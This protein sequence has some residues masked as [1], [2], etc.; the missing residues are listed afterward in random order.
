MP[1]EQMNISLS[2]QMARF[3]RGKVK[4]GEYTNASEVVRDAVRRLQASE[5]ERKSETRD[6]EASLS[7]AERA[8]IRKRVQQGIHDIG[9]G[10][11]EE[12]DE[13]GLRDYFAGVIE[14]GKKRLAAP[15]RP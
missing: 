4:K 9:V 3:I 5:S 6:L 13:E 11:V 1:V 2:P 8:A 12:F 7:L 10:D 14:R 15:K